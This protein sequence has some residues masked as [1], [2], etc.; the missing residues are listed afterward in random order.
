MARKKSA[1][2][3]SPVPSLAQ[4]S[5]STVKRK[6]TDL[7]PTPYNPRQMTRKQAEDL[8]KS[9]AK[10]NLV[11][12]PAVN[13]D[14]RIIAGH[15]RLKIYAMLSHDDPVRY[16]PEIDVRIPSRALTK[17]EA[18]EYMMRSN[19]N[20]GGWDYDS[21][22]AWDEGQLRSWGFDDDQMKK[23]KGID[24]SGGG[25]DAAPREDEAD[26][27]QKKW[28]TKLGQLWKLGLHYITCGDACDPVVMERVLQGDRPHLMVTDP[29]YGVEYKPE[30]R[31]EVMPAGKNQHTVN[32]GKVLNDDRASWAGVFSRS[33]CTV[34]YVW[35]GALH[36]AEVARSLEVCGFE[37]R[38]HLIWSKMNWT[39]CR[40]HYQWRHESCFY[41]VKKDADAHWVGDR[42]QATVWADIVDH[43]P[44]ERGLFY[45]KVDD[46]TLGL[47]PGDMT[48]VWDLKRDK[49][50]GGGHSTQ[51]PLECMARPIRNSSK[52]GDLVFEP[53]SVSGTTLIACENLQRRCRAIELSPGYV[54][55]AI[56]RWVDV[57]NGVP[58]LVK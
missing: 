30:W 58:E 3:P 26:A 6:I 17:D 15:M 46:K 56:Q 9:L 21:L 11:E 52:A 38:A 8:A 22:S 23:I 53:F 13:T 51:K 37:L 24:L 49:A 40:S 20:T 50:C 57:T 7:V 27:L 31:N 29:P 19:V 32:T 4:L 5:W 16:L 55:V 34:L 14:G 25:G 48:S 54:A 28:G 43:H 47:F 44:D 42:K 33:P 35:H 18:D 39:M 1:T 12:V 45:R 36:V 10:F 2:K 41:A